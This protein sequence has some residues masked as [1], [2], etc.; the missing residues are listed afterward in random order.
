MDGRRSRRTGEG[1]GETA[2]RT[3]EGEE[4]EEEVELGLVLVLGSGS[5]W[6]KEGHEEEEGWGWMGLETEGN[7]EGGMDRLKSETSECCGL[8]RIIGQSA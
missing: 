3:T 4:W 6:G 8:E 7:R 2:G 1:L 5:V